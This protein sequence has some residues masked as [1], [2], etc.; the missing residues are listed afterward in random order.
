MKAPQQ[1]Y[2]TLHPI[3]VTE[4]FELVGW[5]PM[6]PFPTS[7]HDNKYI[8]VIIEYLTHWCEAIALSDATAN[9]VAHAL[10]Q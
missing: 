2:E 9:S 7:I 6:G 10:L 3:E 1:S 4:P 5:D 8:L